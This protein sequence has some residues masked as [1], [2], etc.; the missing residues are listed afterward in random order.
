MVDNQVD[1]KSI[2]IYNGS[3]KLN[4]ELVLLHFRESLLV[5][6]DREMLR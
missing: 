4:L 3:E 6:K 2:A 1:R 5:G